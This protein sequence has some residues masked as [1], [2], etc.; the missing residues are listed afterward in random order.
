MAAE[1][2]QLLTLKVEGM[3]CANC[4]QGI[5]RKL[6]KS[7]DHDVHVD[8]TT[9]EASLHLAPHRHAADAV[10]DIESLGYKVI[11]AN[12]HH[13]HSHASDLTKKFY[14]CL[15]LT[16]P[17]VFAHFIP[18]LPEIFSNPWSQLILCIPVFIIGSIHF[19]RSAFMSLKSGV[20]NMDVLI[21]TGILA[22]FGYSL[23]G[24]IMYYGTHEV[25]Q[26]MFFETA[27]SIVTLV[28]LG[29]LLEQ[30]SV[31]KT[32]SAIDELAS[33]MPEKAR[34]IIQIG[35]SE[36]EELIS[37]DLLHAGDIVQVNAGEN[38]P[39]DGIIVTGAGNVNES[40]I[41]GESTPVGKPE[42][43][44]VVAGSV[45]L[46][47]PVRFRVTGAGQQSTLARIIEMVKAAQR[48][49]PPIQKLADKISAWFVPIVL[50][51]SAGTFLVEYFTL[52]FTLSASIMNAIAVLVIS[53]PCAMGL[54][55]PTAVMVGVGRAAKS[56]ILIRSGKSLEELGH[57]KTVVFDKTG[58]LTTGHFTSISI[59]VLNGVKESEIRSVIATLERGSSHPLAKSIVRLLNSPGADTITGIQE[60]KGIGIYGTDATGNKWSVGSWRIAPKDSGA[61]D[62]YVMRNDVLVATADLQDEIKTGAKE[63]VAYLLS[64]DIRV[65]LLSG[66]RKEKCETVAK[67]LGIREVLAEQLP[68]EKLKRI[69]EFTSQGIT[70]MVGDGVND[71]PSLA[72]A[73]VGIS[74]S[75]ASKAAMNSAQVIVP[76]ENNLGQVKNAILIGHYS[77]R[78]IK[79]NLFWAFFYNVVA[80]PIAAAGFLTP[81]V[82]AL[83]MAFSDVI[84]IGNSL[85]LRTR[86]LR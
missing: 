7:G 83:A 56:G 78:T 50:A 2:D 29:N 9:G 74:L 3:D 42:G 39:A 40:M 14:F 17:L 71:A 67:E 61:H 85:L 8:F 57:V 31:K 6:V 4:A 20:P 60:T 21:I 77:M 69:S 37:P 72:R 54:A 25:H 5:T 45:L 16:L 65:V 73:N 55:T 66:D 1:H 12:D 59:R 36:R 62:L 43:S 84:V 28:L 26:Y 41:S 70:V 44:N 33:L 10:A 52:N 34:R 13:G 18:G 11:N 15:G 23:A 81:M 75:D 80:I 82:A 48:E 64:R 49:K 47:G 19:G 22:S 68:E 24:M 76:G 63:T 58:T 86:K 79:Q 53:C 38:F 35:Q 51:I 27:S 30:R 32:S 46:D